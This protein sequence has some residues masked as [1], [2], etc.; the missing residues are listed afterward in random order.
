MALTTSIIT[1]RVPLPSDDPISYAEITFTMSGLDSEGGDVLLPGVS[2]R[3]VLVNSVMPT[4]FD[5]W[6]NTAGYRG[7][8]YLVYARWV[9]VTRDGLQDRYAQLP[10][11]QIGNTASYSLA[12]LLQQSPSPTPTNTY[13]MSITQAEYDAAIDAADLAQ[14]WAQS[15]TPPDVGDPTSKSAKTWAAI[16]EA[17]AS[18]YTQTDTGMLAITVNPSVTLIS[19]IPSASSVGQVA[20][21]NQLSLWRRFVGATS[22]PYFVTAGGDVWVQTGIREDVWLSILE[23]ALDSYVPLPELMPMP[24][25]STALDLFYGAK[26]F[27]SRAAAVT[28]LASI[29]VTVKRFGW[30][31][32]DVAFFVTRK[33]GATGIADLPGWVPDGNPT[34][35]HYGW[36][37]TLSSAAQ[38]TA[39]TAFLQAG[40]SYAVLEPK[41]YTVDYCNAVLTGPML[42]DMR[43]GTIKGSNSASFLTSVV[44]RVDCGASKHRF[45]IAGGTIDGSLR[46][47]TAGVSSGSGLCVRSSDNVVVSDMFFYAGTSRTSGFGDSGFVPEWC[48]NAIVNACR[49]IGWNDHGIYATGGATASPANVG[50]TLTVTNCTFEQ[51]GAGDIRIARDYHRIIIAANQSKDSGKLV[52]TAGG[53]TNFVSADQI[54]ITDNIVNNCF[55]T[56]LDLRYMQAAS[57]GVVS[58]NQIYD[59]AMGATGSAINLRGVSNMQVFG[60]IIKPRAFAQVASATSCTNG[61]Y[62]TDATGDDGAAYVAENNSIFGNTV[63]IFDRSAEAG[64]PANNVAVKNFTASNKNS[65]YDNSLL[66]AYPFDI[67]T[68][69]GGSDGSLVDPRV[70]RLNAAGVG[71]GGV[72]PQ[73]RLAVSDTFE[74]TRGDTSTRRLQVDLTSTTHSIK[75][76]SPTTSGRGLYLNASTDAANT[77]P[78]GGT[79]DL[80]L[81]VLGLAKLTLDQT[82]ITANVPIVLKNYTVAGLPAA[83]TAG[84][85]AVACVSDALTPAWNATVVGGG[86]VKVMV[87]S[88]GTNWKVR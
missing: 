74:V 81:Q 78:S 25:G 6:R 63:Q 48:N 82:L 62:I 66:N 26:P 70:R 14:A 69:T 59:W 40:H 49:F 15:P 32:G 80:R 51:I 12:D 36:A 1:G 61:I 67:W 38:T 4:G 29:P 60:N 45:S 37:D 57:G 35:A 30:V 50:Q 11:V 33:T 86:A 76:F 24:D 17:F 41:V 53:A 56:A 79:V 46:T 54:A 65:I 22:D 2:K 75:S 88:D 52:I 84:A 47:N 10:S 87:M 20:T 72:I 13:W 16:A 83:A 18:F 55:S 9:E 64:P 21:I 58:G 68:G 77:A 31:S 34:P 7:T 27:A 42:L 43:G 19:R 5:L 23:G 3:A 73:S 85:Y 28:A 71:F 8:Y 44:I 39:L